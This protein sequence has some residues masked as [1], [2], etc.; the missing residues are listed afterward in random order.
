MQLKKFVIF[1]KTKFATKQH[2]GSNSLCIGFIGLNRVKLTPF[3]A[4]N[5]NLPKNNVLKIAQNQ[6]IN[7]F[8]E[9]LVFVQSTTFT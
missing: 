1:C 8:Y 5:Y 4:I 2:N 7:W 9:N 6:D 3:I